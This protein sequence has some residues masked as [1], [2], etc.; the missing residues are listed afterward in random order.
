[1][2]TDVSQKNSP[3]TIIYISPLNACQLYLVKI[4]AATKYTWLLFFCVVIDY[5]LTTVFGLTHLTQAKPCHIGASSIGRRQNRSSKHGSINFIGLPR[6][7]AFHFYILRM[8]FYKIVKGKVWNLSMNSGRYYPVHWKM[9]LRMVMSLGKTLP[10]EWYVESSM[11]Y[12]FC[13]FFYTDS[14]EPSITEWTLT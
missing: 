11:T 7:N 8:I 12:F 14:N 10:K 4:V 3:S 1:M 9:S 6:T 5:F 2:L 13:L